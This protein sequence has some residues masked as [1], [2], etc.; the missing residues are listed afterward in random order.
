[1]YIYIY[2]FKIIPDPVPFP[3]PSPT[4]SQGTTLPKVLETTQ[5]YLLLASSFQ[6][7]SPLGEPRPWLHL[8]SFVKCSM[9]LREGRKEKSQEGP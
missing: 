4:Y 5:Y 7:A 3:P 2:N 9:N 1:M 8:C 6:I